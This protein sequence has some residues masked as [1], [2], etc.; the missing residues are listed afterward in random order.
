[1]I[2]WTAAHTESDYDLS[3]SVI[4]PTGGA[5]SG[6]GVTG[7][8]FDATVAGE[9][10]HTLTYTFTD[11]NG[12]TNTATQDIAVQALPTVTFDL[13]ETEACEDEMNQVLSE[14]LPA[15]GT[16]SGPGVNGTIFDASAA[17]P[18]VHPITYTFTDPS[19]CANT[20]TQDITVFALPTVSLV[21][22]TN[23][24]CLANSTL[25]LS[26]GT[27]TGGTYSGPGVTDT[28]FDASSVGVGLHTITYAYIDDNG[29]ENAAT[30]EIEVFDLPTVCLLYTSPSPRDATLSRMPSSA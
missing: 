20:A 16:Y 2:V 25:E 9:G 24:D 21:L 30:A 13:T 6:P 3:T 11:D 4:V 26:D 18:G 1:M 8:N 28:N 27:P 10:T 7:T 14:G 29:C 12:C 22:T 17:G 23:T 19:G 5:F 15:G